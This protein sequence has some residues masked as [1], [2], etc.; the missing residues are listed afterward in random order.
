[1]DENLVIPAIQ[2]GNEDGFNYR[3]RRFETAEKRDQY[4]QHIVS[5]MP[6]ENMKSVSR[7]NLI[8]RVETL[9]EGEN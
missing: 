7:V 5:T 9:N 6:T 3:Y 1:M 8:I 4:Y 2:F